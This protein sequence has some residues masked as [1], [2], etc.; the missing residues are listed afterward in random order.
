MIDGVAEWRAVRIAKDREFFGHPE[1]D[2]GNLESGRGVNI[3]A[4]VE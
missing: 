3:E 1:F 4:G 2:M